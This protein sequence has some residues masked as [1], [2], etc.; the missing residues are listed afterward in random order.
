MNGQ[1]VE[2]L[3]LSQEDAIRAGA[4]DMHK[5]V[6]TMDEVFRLLWKGDCLMGGPTGNN[7]G[8][9]LWFPS[10]P[11]GPNMPVDAPGR[12]FM[13]MIGY[14]GGQFNVCGNKWYG[15]NIDNPQK[16]NLPRS[17][18]I[19]TLNDPLTGA[20]IAIMDANIIS[21]MR[22]GAIAGLGAKYLAKK[23]AEVAGIIGAGVIS[24]TCLMAMYVSME[25]LKEVKVFDTI[26]SKAEEFSEEMSER[27]GIHV[28]PVS[29]LEEALSNCDAVNV[30]IAGKNK[31]ELR[32]EWF[33]RGIFVCLSSSGVE[34][35]DELWL[36]SRL[37]ADNCRQQIE[38]REEADRLPEGILPHQRVQQPTLQKLIELGKLKDDDIED[39]AEIAFGRKAGNSEDE[40]TVIFTSFG[41]ALEDLAWGYMIYTKAVE[42]GIGQKLTMWEEP[43]WY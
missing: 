28:H 23:D 11:R 40:R 33:K 41:M 3:F 25:G 7:H 19:L 42:Q 31:A 22:T 5:C 9:R 4:L 29:S 43:Y 26:G 12:R 24:R 35:P 2:F 36:G 14:L 39:L 1:K 20:P 27:L 21:A 15:A 8:F 18:L 37:V 30:A 34:I 38:A 17:I 13:S 6:E 10:K 32:S 16:R